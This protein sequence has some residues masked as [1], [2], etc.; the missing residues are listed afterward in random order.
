MKK[1]ITLYVETTKE[2][3]IDCSLQ[4]MLDGMSVLDYEIRPMSREEKECFD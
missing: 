4:E 3:G 2:A 1:V